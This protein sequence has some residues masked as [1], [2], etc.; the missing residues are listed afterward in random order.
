M[1]SVVGAFYKAADLSN[2]SESASSVSA[3]G[4]IEWDAHGKTECLS[5]PHLWYE[6]KSITKNVKVIKFANFSKQ[7][8]YVFNLSPPSYI[9][10]LCLCRDYQLTAL[11]NSMQITGYDVNKEV[12]A[13]NKVCH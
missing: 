1:N 7:Q 12:C 10:Y 6:K 9:R 8:A 5:R 4:S 3:A 11:G 2:N 13:Q